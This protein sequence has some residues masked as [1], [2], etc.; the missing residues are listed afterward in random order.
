MF[1]TQFEGTSTDISKEVRDLLDA[2]NFSG[3]KAKTK[4]KKVTF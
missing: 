2:N 1:K 3:V 4:T